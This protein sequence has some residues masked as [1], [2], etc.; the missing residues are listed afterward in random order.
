MLKLSNFI[1]LNYLTLRFYAFFY[2]H[3]MQYYQRHRIISIDNI[4]QTYYTNASQT[5]YINN[6][7]A[8]AHSHVAGFVQCRRRT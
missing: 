3:C 1:D 2:Y 6:V 7:Y 4:Q 8:A 5:I